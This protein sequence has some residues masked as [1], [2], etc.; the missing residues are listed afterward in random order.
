MYLQ[1]FGNS[2]MA[3][4]NLNILHRNYFLF[5]SYSLLFTFKLAVLDFSLLQ[6]V[7]LKFYFPL[8]VFYSTVINFDAASDFSKRHGQ[9]FS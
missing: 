7:E 3:E 2:I 4:E 5:R 1:F 8:L 6:F 9:F